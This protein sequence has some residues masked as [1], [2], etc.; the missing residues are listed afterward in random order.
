MSSAIPFSPL[1]NYMKCAAPG[2]I[3]YIRSAGGNLSGWTAGNAAG[4]AD[5]TTGDFIVPMPSVVTGYS[6]IWF[7]GV[8]NQ[9]S[10][11]TLPDDNSGLAWNIAWDGRGGTVTIDLLTAGSSSSINNAAGTGTFTFGTAPDNTRFTVTLTDNTDP[12]R[13]FRIWQQRY[14]TNYTNGETFNPDFIR[15]V[16]RFDTIRFVDWIGSNVTT[17]DMDTF[18]D[19]SQWATTAYFTWNAQG[20]ASGTKGL[21]PLSLVAQL[22]DLTGCKVHFNIPYKA[23]D[24]CVT[25]IA[26]YMK[27]NCQN[28]VKYEYSNEAWNSGY[29]VYT[30]C[31]TQG[32]AN[33][34]ADSARQNKY[35]GYRAAQCMNIIK[36]VYNDTSRWEGILAT[37]TVSTSV[38]N[39]ILTGIAK[40]KS[41]TSSSLNV[42]DLFKGLYVTGYFGDQQNGQLPTAV[43]KANPGSVTLAFHGYANG[44]KLRF[45]VASGM[46]QLNNVDV[47]ITVVDANTFT[48]GVDT[49]GYTTW[50]A[51]GNVGNYCIDATLFDIMDQ[52]L[53][54]YN[55]NRV[56]YPTKYTYFNQQLA[57][58]LQHGTCTAGFVTGVYVDNL[59]ST[60][61]PAQKTIAD[62][63]G[64]LLQQYESGSQFVGNFALQNPGN[65]QFSE[66]LLASGH[67]AEIA[68]VYAA[69]Y[70][71][72]TG[73][74]GVN[75]SKYHMGGIST[76]FG[77]W[78][79]M[80]TIPESPSNPVWQAVINANGV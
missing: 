18:T 21:F 76:F 46:T 39:A 8:I 14:N 25:D 42:S 15:E 60:Y 41:D 57:A 71:G 79:G 48:I 2:N 34:P 35:Y 40:W 12:P 29:P 69:G 3:T 52:S 51:G 65:A 31:Q 73:L 6:W 28:V 27:A 5:A 10:P 72:F 50:T 11:P 64:L 24:Q 78:G 59:V 17:T 54:N 75:P 63:N 16:R 68:V 9:T 32:S 22:S 61:W 53:T 37:Q 7:T 67:S 30:Y 26:T 80:Q 74:G 33:W 66:Y 4:Y 43:T 19:S 36:G 55:S 23:S 20:V 62:A 13:N 49:S 70:S 44:Q 58:S 38:T 45:F 56:T 1:L 77:T 47:T